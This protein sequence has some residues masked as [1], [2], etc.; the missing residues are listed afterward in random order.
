MLERRPLTVV[1]DNMNWD[2]IQEAHFFC[3]VLLSRLDRS[4]RYE[5]IEQHK[6]LKLTDDVLVINLGNG[7]D[8]V[9]RVYLEAGRK[10]IGMVAWCHSNQESM[11]YTDKVDYVL[12]PFYV[13][14]RMMPAGRC[15]EV[16]WFPIGYKVG[17][18]PR[19]PKLLLKS[20]QRSLPLFFAGAIANEERGDLYQIFAKHKLPGMF[21]PAAGFNGEGAIGANLYRTYME[22]AV[23]ALIPGGSAGDAE[24][25]RL[26]EA[27]ELGAMP[28]T[29][30]HEYLK[31]STAPVVTLD[32]WDSLPQWVSDFF[33]H[34]N[35]W[36][37]ADNCQSWQSLWWHDQKISESVRI[38]GV[39][40]RSFGRTYGEVDA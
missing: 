11:K 2:K 31:L 27:F 19:D 16:A 29:L 8:D 17:V 37:T 30:D 35:K 3:D 32:S 14:G 25:M 5:I 23:F 33:S 18:G 36:E 22:N 26:Y 13:P 28:I 9:V 1:C 12:R 7:L 15:A 38:A 34:G 39:I 24:T 40:N 4:V 21:I 20:S 6:D 10:N